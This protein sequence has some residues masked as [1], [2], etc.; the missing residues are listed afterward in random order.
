M[1]EVELPYPPSVNHY[2]RHVGPRVLI[3][4]Q[5]RAFREKVRSIL[6]ACGVRPLG[7]TLRVVIDLHP[8]DRRR[9]DCDNLR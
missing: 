5:G 7:G 4:R 2:W 3:S 8:P 6:E 1:I 9:R